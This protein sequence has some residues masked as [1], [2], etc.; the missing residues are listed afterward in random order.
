MICRRIDGFSF[1]WYV[2]ANEGRRRLGGSFT[3]AS[4][5]VVAFFA[6]GTGFFFLESVLVS[7]FEEGSSCS[8]VA[9][10]VCGVADSRSRGADFV[11]SADGGR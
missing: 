11:L 10:G 9:C 5:S 7:D 4:L 1:I 6:A 3:V 8:V 2:L